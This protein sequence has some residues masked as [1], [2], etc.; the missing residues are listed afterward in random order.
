MPGRINGIDS[1]TTRDD[2]G[3]PDCRS[4]RSNERVHHFAV[5]GPCLPVSENEDDFAA[6]HPAPKVDTALEPI[7]IADSPPTQ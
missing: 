5:I 4:S 3:S 7:D 6:R 1:V 2:R